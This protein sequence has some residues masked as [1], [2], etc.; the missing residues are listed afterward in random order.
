[1]TPKETE[2]YK[3]YIS[4]VKRALAAEKRKFGM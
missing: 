2:K 1:M 3:K 4:D